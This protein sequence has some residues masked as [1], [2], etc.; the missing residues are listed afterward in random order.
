MLFRDPPT[1]TRLRGLVHKAF[2]PRMIE[3]LR[4]HIEAITEDLLDRV[5]DAGSM[6]VIADLATPLPVKVIAE[7]LGVPLDDQETFRRWSRDL[8]G[9][10]EFLPVGGHDDL[11]DRATQAAIE[12]DAYFRKLA[13]ERRQ[14]PQDDL[15]TALVQAEDGGETLTE[16]E[17]VATCSLLLIAGHETTVNLIGNGT[18]A[19][20]RHRDQWDKLTAELP[21]NPGLIRSTVE[22]LL[23]Y[24]S[25]VQMT[26]RWI[27]EDFDFE[28]HKFR[29]GQQVAMLFGA[30]NRDPQR[31]DHPNDLDVTREDN[32]HLAF[33]NGIHFCLGAPLA[34]VEGQIGT[35][36]LARRMPDLHLTD[37]EPE[38]RDTYVLRGLKALHVRF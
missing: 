8:A 20:M 33:G 26:S 13:A 10:L 24:D 4:E 34:R 3:T 6:D 36:A 30:A 17:L 7:M 19:L 23:R 16:D 18:L 11:Y 1:H 27:V 28:G 15:L 25:P 31:F 32:K 14:S 38:H 21:H 2:T 5:Q 29:K 12:F 37:E 22:E 35:A 9:T